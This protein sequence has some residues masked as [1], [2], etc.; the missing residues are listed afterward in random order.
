MEDKNL[1]IDSGILSDISNEAN[2][3]NIQQLAER[4]AEEGAQGNV[5]NMDNAAMLHYLRNQKTKT[6][7]REYKINRNDKCPCGSG[8]KY[9]KCCLQSGKYEK[10]VEKK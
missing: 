9:K 4:R 7:V 6:L 3:T 1:Y 5:V 10:L 8:K 2:T